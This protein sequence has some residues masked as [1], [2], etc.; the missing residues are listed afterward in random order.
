MPLSNIPLANRWLATALET[1]ING[2]LR[3]DP[4]TRERLTD[5]DG[6]I[7]ALEPEGYG[8]VLYLHPGE[9]GIRVTTES[10]RAPDLSIHAS[11]GTLLQLLN[12]DEISYTE[13]GLHGDVQLAR[14]LQDLLAG[15]DPDWEEPLARVF[16]DL[17]GHRLA[18]LLRLGHTRGRQ[19][20]A[21]LL[22]AGRDFLHYESGALPP[23][24]QVARFLD[25]VDRL[26][27]DCERLEAR[28]RRLQQRL[29]DAG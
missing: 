8:L 2:A 21:S 23:R 5:L 19:A 11:P 22:D 6:R 26:R 1:A 28:V 24:E 9:A 27:D 29:P 12:G 7:I 20:T 13:L 4:I 15:L 10:Q 25:E 17:A 14:Q 16:G 3:L 18:D